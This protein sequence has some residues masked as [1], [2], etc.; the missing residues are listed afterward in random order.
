MICTADHTTALILAIAILQNVDL[1]DWDVCQISGTE[2]VYHF[3]TWA[4][5]RYHKINNVFSLP[6][7]IMS[8]RLE[9]VRIEAL[10]EA[11]SVR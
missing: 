3:L 6:C 9:F 7:S 2:G 11:S 10:S 4:M 5:Q 8:K 1:G